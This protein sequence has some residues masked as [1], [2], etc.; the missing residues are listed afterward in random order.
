MKCGNKYLESSFEVSHFKAKVKSTATSTGEIIVVLV[1][2]KM[3]EII[4]PKSL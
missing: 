1:T 2:L 3:A 4:L